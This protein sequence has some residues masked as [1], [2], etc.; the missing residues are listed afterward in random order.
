MTIRERA[1]AAFAAFR[2]KGAERDT[3]SLDELLRFL[4]VSKTNDPDALCEAVYYACIKVL[5]ESIGKLPLK[6]QQTTPNK[7]VRIAREHPYYRML[8]ERPNRFI[9]ATTFWALMEQCRDDKGNG[10]AWIDARDPKHP[11]LW[12]LDPDT[13]QVYY[14]NAC[15]LSEV[16]DVYYQVSTSKGVLVLGSEEVLHFPGHRT[17]DGLVG[18]PVRETL[19]NTILGNVKA[20]EYLNKLYTSGFS[21][22]AVLQYTGGLDDQKVKTLVKGMEAY[23]KGELAGTGIENII[24]VPVG[25]T[26]TPLN[27]KLADSQ[28]L[29]TKQN[30]ALQIASA[31]GVKPYQVGD[32]T[33]S[34][35]ASAEAQQLSFLVDTLLYIVKQYEEEIGYKLLTDDERAAGYHVKFNTGV[36]LRADQKTQIETLVSAVSNFLMT[37]DEARERLDLPSLPGGDQLIG[38]GST[39][40]LT[41]VGSQ[42]GAKKPAEDD[43][44]P[45]DNNPGGGEPEGDQQP[46]QADDHK[47]LR[48]R[49]KS[50]G[51]KKQP[52][53]DLPRDDR[54]GGAVGAPGSE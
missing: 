22:K 36:I 26:L 17:V 2:G 19:A 11:Q 52:A 38:N 45:P 18:I 7:G 9:T 33:K 21:A 39:I 28:F 53:P 25:M 41:A 8:N 16:P 46:A 31:F 32:Y 42:Y 40:P 54:E 14:D 1:R 24:P 49:R 12:P 6:I 51:R 37:A 15:M 5:S 47:S 20:Q 35:Y 30:T 10:Y 3:M 29:E 27:L 13:V 50:N 48:E 34:S 44:T 23:A 4:G 43:K